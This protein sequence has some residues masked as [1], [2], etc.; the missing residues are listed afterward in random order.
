MDLRVLFL[1]SLAV[2]AILLTLRKGPILTLGDIWTMILDFLL[3]ITLFLTVA[4]FMF[5]VTRRDPLPLIRQMAYQ[6]SLQQLVSFEDAIPARLK[7]YLEVQSIKR[8]DT[9]GDGFREWV[10]FYMYEL[11]DGIKPVEGAVYDSDRGD[12]PVLFPYSL[13]PTD[14]DY[15]AEGIEGIA[16]QVTLDMVQVISEQNGP[17]QQDLPELIVQGGNTLS[18]FT[19]RENS[20]EWDFPRNAPPR[21]PSI[22][23]FR[24][25]GGVAFDEETNRVT[26]YDR[27]G[28]ER[29][30]LAIRSVY[31]LNP[32]TNTYLDSYSSQ[33]LAAPIISTIDFFEGPPVEVLNT[34]YPEKVVLAFYAATCGTVNDTLC[35][36]TGNNNWEPEQFLALNSEAYAEFRN[37]N[38]EYF[39]LTSFTRMSN[40]SIA[41]LR[42]YPGLETDS[43][44]LVTGQGRDV[45]TG[46][47]PQCNLVE[48]ELVA[49]DRPVEIFRYSMGIVDGQWKI[50]RR[51]GDNDPVC[52][53]AVELLQPLQ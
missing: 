34:T 24:G 35:R 41:G 7:D 1:V 11:R 49:N 19:F 39:G 17:D 40:I 52:P 46:E 32:A 2:T 5:L 13:R 53:D 18:I 27:D 48:V 31:A 21:Y 4:T 36:N 6:L 51:V 38:P 20:A 9:D 44:L 8:V 25:S 3:V 26:V 10:V 30:Q 42:Y 12:P 33:K 47:H 16:F 28:F 37:D 43:D 23:S 50:F 15:L 14:R 45:V 22:G 29:S